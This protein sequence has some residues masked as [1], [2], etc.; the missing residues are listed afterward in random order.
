[1][2]NKTTNTTNKNL[3][4]INIMRSGIVRDGILVDHEFKK[5]EKI[6]IEKIME[7]AKRSLE[8][9]I[10]SSIKETKSKK[11]KA[12]YV[13]RIF[14]EEQA[15]EE[16]NVYWFYGTEIYI[17]K[18][19]QGLISLRGNEINEKNYCIKYETLFGQRQYMNPK[20]VDYYFVVE[21]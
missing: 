11:Q 16:G 15:A 7:E 12:K 21:K 5:L 1:M 8:N 13:I 9:K 19:F 14:W 6:M 2:L 10:G 3:I 17:K 18:M 4:G 20:Y